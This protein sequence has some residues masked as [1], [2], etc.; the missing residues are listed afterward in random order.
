MNILFDL[1]ATQPVGNAKY[2]GG[3]EYA[4][5][6]FK[7]I[8]DKSTE[9][10]IFCIYDDKKYIDEQVT[11]LFHKAYKI[12]KIKNIEEIEKIIDNYEIDV[13]YS[14]LPL[15]FK[16]LSINTKYILTIHGLRPLELSNDI[17][18]LKYAVKI[19]DYLKYAVK[20]Y[21]RKPYLKY[22]HE[23]FQKLFHSSKN[24]YVVTVSNHSRYSVIEEYPELKKDK[25][26][27]FYAPPLSIENPYSEDLLTQYGIKEKK[28]FLIISANRW[29][30]NA[31]RAI[32][33][34]KQI[35]DK[36]KE[37][38]YQ[39]VVVGLK[40]RKMVKGI[41][42]IIV[43]DYVDRNMLETLYKYAFSFIYPTLNEGFGYPPIDCMKY[44]TPVIASSINSIPEL[45]K[46][47]VLYFNPYSIREIKNRMLQVV[48]DEK[49]RRKLIA[50]GP[51]HAENL[52][53]RELEDLE[54]LT[55][56]ILGIPK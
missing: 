1:I 27:K 39:M 16:K 8:I 35:V 56:F 25:V 19:K 26:L 10:K 46:D 37:F 15:K 4:K 30:K 12:I 53:Q 34:Y 22:R 40:N 51:E 23:E 41:D 21:L 50:E 28:Y 36:F 44:G 33:A 13:F 38:D 32:I 2:H 14:A 17:Y 20:K 7:K 11:K 43:L 6:V 52:R 3:G 31:Y 29:E 55:D 45:Q 9:N 5:E 42:K 47:K 48:Y 24:F 54:E 49:L 18:E